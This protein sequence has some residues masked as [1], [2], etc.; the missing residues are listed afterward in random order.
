MKVSFEHIWEHWLVVK[1][2]SKQS[3]SF[4]QSPNWENADW[5]QYVR[6]SSGLVTIVVMMTSSLS[7]KDSCQCNCPS[8][9]WVCWFVL[10]VFAD[11]HIKVSGQREAVLL[12]KARILDVL[13][14]RV[15]FQL[16]TMVTAYHWTSSHHLNADSRNARGDNSQNILMIGLV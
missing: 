9:T 1:W 2:C 7:L 5:T 4:R 3:Y 15:S 16:L 14:T 13:D 6:S 8:L 10:I 12:A 11:P